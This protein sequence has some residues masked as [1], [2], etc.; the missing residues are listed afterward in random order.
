METN[1]A[2]ALAICAVNRHITSLLVSGDAGVGKSFQIRKSMQVW[3][4]PVLELPLHISE[5]MLRETLDV[6]KT[7]QTGTKVYEKNLLERAAGQFVYVD[8]INLLRPNLLKGLMSH[9]LQDQQ[10]TFTLVGSMNPSAGVLGTGDLEKFDLFISL[11]EPDLARRVAVLKAIQNEDV[12]LD[13]PYTKE[14]LSKAKELVQEMEPSQA[15]MTLASSYCLQ[16]GVGGNQVDYVLLE[17][18][19][20]IAALDGKNYILPRHMEEA[21]LYVLPHRMRRDEDDKPEQQPPQ[22]DD[23]HEQEDNDDS[24]AQDESSNDGDDTPDDGDDSTP[25]NSVNQP[26]EQEEDESPDDDNNEE[27]NGAQGGVLPEQIAQINRDLLGMKFD[28]PHKAD[29]FK[30]NGSGKRM[31]TRTDQ[32]QGRYVRAHIPKGKLHDLA[33][34]ATIRAAA[35]YQKYREKGNLAIVVKPSDWRSKE[36]EKRIGRTF[37]FVVDASGSM[38]AKKRME[39]VK[40]AI[41]ALL[42]DAYEKR[43]K[44]GLIA[45]RRESAEMLLPFTRSI[46]M[47]QRYLEELPT[48]GKTPLASGLELAYSQLKGLFLR[49][50]HEAPVMVL[51][52]DGRATYAAGDENPVEGARKWARALSELPLEA[53]V[54]DTEKEFIS[55]GIAK[56][57][58]KDLEGSYYALQDINRHTVIQAVR[59]VGG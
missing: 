52:T 3:N 24:S 44:V 37:L 5:D 47:A 38:G 55:L 46:E 17:T 39:A 15:M 45:F 50:P 42:Q 32:L 54:M 53:I 51:V 28:M 20:A 7:L 36:R 59:R 30:R 35:P 58:A 4:M 1:L 6:E 8:D 19:M 25:N 31:L 10:G 11:E 2:K 40:G 23:N 41:Y 16:A 14:E 18:A 57:L 34:D 27:D 22:N 33:L 29:R 9:S 48:G 12:Y 56:L 49:E 26:E 13:L 43:D 21:S